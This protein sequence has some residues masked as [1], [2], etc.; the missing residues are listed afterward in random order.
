M[1]A[2]LVDRA[3]GVALVVGSLLMT[4][5]ALLYALL[6]PIGGGPSDFVRVVSNSNWKWL[7]CVAFVGVLLMLAGIG[8]V[9]ARVKAAAGLLGLVG[10]LF[11]ETAFILQACKITWE[12]FLYPIIAAHSESAF[13]IS[14]ALIIRDPGVVAFLLISVAAIFIGIS[15]F[16]WVLYR[17]AV[18]AKS[19]AILVFV[20]ALVYAVGPIMSIYLAVVG[21]A[22]L[23]IGCAMLGWRLI[24]TDQ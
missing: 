3:G 16:C 18:F 24:K 23:A 12:L 2:K 9:Y 10:F 5:Y 20:G 7:A 17:S 21:V 13:L 22:T 6:L 14:D 19:A 11:I 15:L 8:A 4:V 1:N